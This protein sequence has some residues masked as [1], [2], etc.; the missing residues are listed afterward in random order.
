MTSDSGAGIIAP[1]PGDTEGDSGHVATRMLVNIL[2]QFHQEV[3]IFTRA[4][5]VFDFDNECVYVHQYTKPYSQS[6][7]YNR[8]LGQLIY[9]FKFAIGIFQTSRS[10]DL[11]IFGGGGFP[12]PAISA[13]IC[14]VHIIFRVGGVKYKELPTNSYRQL[15]WGQFLKFFRRFQYAL[16]DTIVVLSPSLIEFAD[17]GRFRY[18]CSVFNHYYFDLELFCQTNKYSQ[19]DAILGHIGVSQTKGTMRLLRAF[20]K[21]GISGEYRLIILGDGPQVQEAKSYAKDREL[22]V[23]FPGY[24]NRSDIPEYYNMMKLYVNCSESEGV[25]KAM[26]EAMACGTPVA[27]APVGGVPDYIDE[28]KNGYIIEDNSPSQ[29]AEDLS[30]VLDDSAIETVAKRSREYVYTNFSY[31]STVTGYY[32]LI[33]N[34]TAIEIPPPPDEPDEPVR[35]HV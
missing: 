8:L 28:Y 19:R 20:D 29:L 3:H 14:R 1:T 27:V 25:P 17:V 2:L 6:P 34:E 4:T 30:R 13:Q 10:L 7:W 24:L 33:N 9:Q 35:R 26:F 23:K 32:K 18:K 12:I 5:A 11:I 22:A 15:T 21:S 31:Q 16:A